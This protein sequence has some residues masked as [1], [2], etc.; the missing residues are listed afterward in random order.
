MSSVPAQKC[1]RSLKREIWSFSSG[2]ETCPALYADNYFGPGE[3]LSDLF[4]MKVD[5]VE[6]TTIQNPFFRD[7][8]YQVKEQLYGGL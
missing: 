2:L 1:T 7:A 4:G 8:I 6:E 3:S 5:L